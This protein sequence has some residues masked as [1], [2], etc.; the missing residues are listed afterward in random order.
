MTAFPL[1]VVDQQFQCHLL[2]SESQ[3][4][5]RRFFRTTND[6]VCNMSGGC[7]LAPCLQLWCLK[8]GRLL[9]TTMNVA[10]LRA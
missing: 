10:A 8:V 1:I 3:S 5:A 4:A 6:T 2:L 9:T 7:G